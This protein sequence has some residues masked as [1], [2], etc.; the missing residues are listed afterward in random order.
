MKA[1]IVT[2]SQTT[3]CSEISWK[4]VRT[5]SEIRSKVI[6]TCSEVSLKVI[7]LFNVVDSFVLNSS[8]RDTKNYHI[9]NRL[10]ITIYRLEFYRNRTSAVI[11]FK[12][13][14]GIYEKC[15]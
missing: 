14:I 7:R 9:T 5:C 2:Q 12:M 10:V 13:W 1:K 3:D 4:F 11:K 6:R 15:L 8:V